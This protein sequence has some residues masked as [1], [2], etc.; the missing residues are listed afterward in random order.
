MAV[1]PE[2]AP[3]PA[4]EVAVQVVPMRRRHLRSVL[5]IEAQV[6]PRPW[7]LGLFLSELNL[8]VARSYFVARVEGRVVGYG[9]LMLSLEDA[10]I[11]TLAVDPQWQRRKLGQRLLAVLAGEAVRRG[12]QN[13]TLE[14]RVSNAA[15]QGLYRRFGLAPAG[16]RKGYYVESGEDAMVMW[17]H[18]INEDAYAQR[19]QRLW[20]AIPGTTLVEHPR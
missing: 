16:I 11:T 2:A 3:P 19:L 5:Q 10:H 1:R 17:A 6:Y 9:G 20:D 18:G 12:S 4:E 8:H 13:L 14:V 15:A 7:T